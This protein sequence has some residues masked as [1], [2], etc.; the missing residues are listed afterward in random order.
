MRV[1]VVAPDLREPGG[2]REKTL[3]VARA[4][5][6]QLGASVRLLSLA[7]SRGDDSSILIHRP[8]TW[9]RSLVTRYSAE[10]FSVDH[11]GAIGAEI[12]AARYG[13]RGAMLDLV[14]DCDVVHVVC[15]TPAFA[16]VVSGFG[17]PVVVHFASFVRH[18]RRRDH[19]RREYVVDR[20]RQ[21]M[22]SAVTMIERRALRRADAIIAVN[23]T[24]LAEA[25]SVARP[26]TPAAVVHTGVDTNWF[27]PGPYR[28]D[29]FLLT[30]GRLSDPRKNLPVLLQAYAAARKRA[31][32]V[33]SLVLAGPT[34]PHQNDLALVAGLG[35][36]EV[37]RYTGP[38]SRRAL[39]DIY[40][41]AS[42]FVLSSDE[43]GQGIAIVEAMASGLPVVATS[44]VGP[45]EVITDG[46][47]GI[48]TP[49]RS[50]SG[51]ADAI[52]NLSADTVR[53]RHMSRAAR[54]RAVR[55]F[56]LERAGTSLCSVYREQSSRL[57]AQ[58]LS[59]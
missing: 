5:R 13:R 20:W 51:L 7:T 29:G 14:A 50:V 11:V 8:S 30:V 35:L 54:A 24:R 41:N 33:P 15:G 27:S 32:H 36:T 38:L 34:P 6:D 52:V 48:L 40:R 39:A 25:R 31:P 43:E 58:H 16:N 18:E 49:V 12:E 59:R 4:L 37:V 56:S 53:R 9:T 47:E 17:G 3:F 46:V 21:V 28:E 45:S 10:E 19:P 26:G 22:T 55:D 1:G 57:D 42:A 44:C 23:R 2:V